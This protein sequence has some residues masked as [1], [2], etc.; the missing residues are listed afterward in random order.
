MDIEIK[1]GIDFQNSSLYVWKEI[2]YRQS[3]W[4]PP[5]RVK[6]SYTRLTLQNA[7]CQVVFYITF[8]LY[9]YCEPYTIQDIQRAYI[10]MLTIVYKPVPS[11]PSST[12]VSLSYNLHIES[13][14]PVIFVPAS[15]LWYQCGINFTLKRPS[16]LPR[17]QVVQSV[18]FSVVTVHSKVEV[19]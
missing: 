18:S 13:Q 10:L 11:A 7:L 2:L 17:T 19:F 3:W 5:Q 16:F 8:W 12:G 14:L 9:Y 15:S 6:I 1:Y 4:D